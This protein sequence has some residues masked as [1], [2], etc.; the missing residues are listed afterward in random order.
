MRSFALASLWI[1]AIAGPPLPAQ[2][3][4]SSQMAYVLD[5]REA[6]QPGL[7]QAEAALVEK[8]HAEAAELL[9]TLLIRAE[10]DVASIGPELH[11]SVREKARALMTELPADVLAAVREK[12]ASEAAALLARGRATN[13]PAALWRLVRQ[14]T[15]TRAA[16][17]ALEILGDRAMERGDAGKA[18]RCFQRYLRYYHPIKAF[19]DLPW[20]R[21]L[22]KAGAAAARVGDAAGLDRARKAAAPFVASDASVTVGH[23]THKLGVFLSRLTPAPAEAPP[24]DWTVFGGGPGRNV[25]PSRPARSYECRW[26]EI[27]LP[28]PDEFQLATEDKPASRAYSCM[29]PTYPA[30]TRDRI[31]YFNGRLLGLYDLKHGTLL[32]RTVFRDTNPGD[33]AYMPYRFRHVTLGPKIVYLLT[34]QDPEFTNRPTQRVIHALSAR[35]EDETLPKRWSRGGPEDPDPVLKQASLSGSP[36]LIGGRIYVAGTLRSTDDRVYLF[37]FDPANGRLAW[38]RFLCA[39]AGR[40]EAARFQ[41]VLGTEDGIDPTHGE[42]MV[43]ATRGVIYVGTNMGVVA[44]ISEGDGEILW[45]H[46]YPRR[47]RPQNPSL[48]PAVTPFP[49]LDN[50][51]MIDD[52]R[53]LLTPRDSDRLHVLAT[54]PDRTRGLVRIA[55][56]AK[57]AVDAEFLYLIGAEEGRLYLAERRWIGATQVYRVVCLDPGEARTSEVWTFEIPHV[58]TDQDEPVEFFSG[59]AQL[60]GEY[61]LVPTNKH[62]HGLDVRTGERRFSLAPSD[63]MTGRGIPT[64]GNVIPAGNGFLC[65]FPDAL[66]YWEAPSTAPP[67]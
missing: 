17:D 64:F 40:G 54:E 25:H 59:R 16:S 51:V 13:D 52:H 66:C 57:T 32:A 11:V 35:A 60:T 30:V 14:F 8:R 39:G 18:Y 45:L 29:Q 22:A 62:L 37:A 46:R 38:K 2:A 44:A 41:R 28:R 31:Y 10:D 1:L 4:A 9:L 50:P 24:G 53:L 58:R 67:K 61:V 23:S 3:T 19:P 7:R 48:W 63:R 34:E 55:S 12:R 20:P 56:I 49:W 5:D 42:A 15:F 33:R 27:D 6:V 26:A 47:S 36:L 65:T 21:I 43:C